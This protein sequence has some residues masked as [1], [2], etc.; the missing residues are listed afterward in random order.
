MIIW[1]TRVSTLPDA[2]DD[3]QVAGLSFSSSLDT[4][5]PLSYHFPREYPFNYCLNSLA[6]HMR[7]NYQYCSLSAKKA[8]FDNTDKYYV[9]SSLAMHARSLSLFL[10]FKKTF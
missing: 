4:R 5:E 8:L 6:M 9:N 10:F 3:I 1:R 2:N 7:R